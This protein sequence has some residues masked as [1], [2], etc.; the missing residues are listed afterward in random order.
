VSDV[1]VEVPKKLL[2]L[3]KP[4]RYK[5]AHG[6]RGGAKSWGFARALLTLGASKPLRILCG[7]EIQNSIADSVHRLLS[8]QAKALQLDQF[9]DIKETSI[10]GRNGTEFF[11]VGLRQQDVH[12]IKSF[13]GCD[14]AWVEE[15]QAVS[16]RSWSILSPTIRKPGSEIWVSFNP[17]L[18]TDP[19][20]QRFVV[21]PP[22]SAEVV[23]IN[24]NDNPWFPAELEQE[25]LDMLKRDPDAY[26]NI[27]EGKCKSVVDGAIYKREVEALY[28]DKRVRPMP[29]DPKLK[30]HTVWDL[31]FNDA[32]TII[33]AQRSGTSMAI[34]DYIEDSHRTL[35]EYVA[36]L[37]AKP[38]V[39]GHDWIPHD[40]ASKDHKYGQSSEEVLRSLG[41]SVRVLPR[42]DVEEGIKAARLMFPRCYFDEAKTVRLLNCLKRYRRHISAS[43]NE[44]SGPVHDEYSHGADAF[45]YLAMI[46]D[47]LKNGDER[48]KVDMSNK[49]R[50]GSEHSWLA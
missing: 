14:I 46:A 7:R 32:M 19:T 40:G 25:R 36:D 16:E 42:D 3:F 9:Y 50:I 29:Y 28:V 45:R 2:F 33:F 8:D 44:P 47:Q 34:I 24:W 11:F 48:K 20:Y 12:K 37:K 21:N 31:G 15:A 1:V 43:T 38:Y 23:Q 30:V 6:G 18:D 4:K 49:P 17:E 26:E 39:Y 41:R 13:E 22:D 5:V 10:R 35:A 27:W